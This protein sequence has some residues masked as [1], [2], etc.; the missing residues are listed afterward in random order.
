[1]ESSRGETFI[2]IPKKTPVWAF[3]LYAFLAFLILG[4]I[5][6]QLFNIFVK[7]QEQNHAFTGYYK[8]LKCTSLCPVE[9]ILNED[10]KQV[11]LFDA[12][13]QST[14]EKIYLDSLSERERLFL[15]ME[16]SQEDPNYVNFI[17]YTRTY[18][19]CTAQMHSNVN[20]DQT[21]CFQDLFWSMSDDVDLS[22]VRIPSYTSYAF[23]I[24][25]FSCNPPSVKVN[26]IRG[27]AKNLSLIFILEDI[28]GERM[29]I[30]SASVPLV[31]DS[32]TYP[33]ATKGL[34]RLSKIE[35]F[36]QDTSTNQ[37]VTNDIWKSCP[38]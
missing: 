18:A 31:G 11:R 12:S 20:F 25:D 3:V 24:V 36:A 8:S 4:F 37:K 5:F 23:S 29:G 35:F 34:D 32:Q 13:C 28:R 7:T 22:E 14:C 16:Q 38:R 19:R 17:N 6:Y 1:M 27:A 2:R 9:N 15:N 26:H 21:V 33:L 30:T 10:Q